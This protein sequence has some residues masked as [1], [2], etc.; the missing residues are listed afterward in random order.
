MTQTSSNALRDEIRK[1]QIENWKGES[2]VPIDSL[3]H[4]LTEPRIREVFIE[5]GLP[6]YS[7][8]EAVKAVLSGGH[9]V[10]GILNEIEHEEL[11]LQVKKDVDPY[12]DKPID[13]GLPYD[14]EQAVKRFLP[15][16][17]TY[18][19]FF[20]TQWRFSAPVFHRNLHY[21]HLHAHTILPFTTNVNLTDQDGATAIVARAELVAC[22]QNI[23]QERAGMVPLILKT[24]SKSDQV[25][26][27]FEHEQH[28]LSL[29]RALQ[30]P[31]IVEFFAAY[32]FSD[33]PTFI[34]AP[35]DCDLNHF[36]R[37][38]QARDFT[39]D[40]IFNGLCGL[41]SALCHLHNYFL[42]DHNLH[43]IGCHYDIHPG[44]ILVKGHT[45]ILS[46]FGL[47]RLKA[48]HQGSKSTFK[49]G[50]MDYYAPECQDWA[51]SFKTGDIGRPSDIWSLGCVMAEILTT[52]VL[53]PERLTQFDEERR[54]EGLTT[55]H[56]RGSENP[57]VTKWIENLSQLSQASVH[58]QYHLG[59]VAKTLKIS[60]ND[61][62]DAWEL[63]GAMSLL[64]H[65]LRH[66]SIM[67]KL[68]ILIPSKPYS[69]EI[70]YERLRIWS[71][72]V[73][74]EEISHNTSRSSWFY[75]IK[76][77]SSLQNSMTLLTEIGTVITAMS[78]TTADDM[79]DAIH[80]TKLRTC[81]DGL[82][83]TQAADTV[84]HMNQKLDNVILG[85]NPECAADITDVAAY[86]R[87]QLLIAVRQAIEAT[88]DYQELDQRLLIDQSNISNS[89]EWEG[90]LMG[91]L[92]T[93]DGLSSYCITEEYQYDDAWIGR[94]TELLNR[95][96][97][98]VSFLHREETVNR[99]PLLRANAFYHQ[100]HR[101]AYGIAFELP[102]PSYV[103]QEG[104][105]P[106]T[107]VQMIERLSRRTER[108]SLDDVYTLAHRIADTVLSFHKASWLHKGISSYKILLFPKDETR[109][110]HS[111][112]SARM[113][114]FHHSR[115]SHDLFTA[116]PRGD[117]KLRE[118]HHP[119]YRRGYIP[120]KE[121]FDYYSVGVVLLEL[122]RWRTLES[123][124][125]K[126]KKT[127]DPTAVTQYLLDTQVPDLKSSM[128]IRYHEAV[129]T[130][131]KTFGVD[132][133]ELE[134]QGAWEL[135]ET[136]VVNALGLG[137][138]IS[139]TLEL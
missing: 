93:A 136:Q 56:K 84:L 95:V 83:Q 17:Q 21:R 26:E 52:V 78:D 38:D 42:R 7:L 49:G 100:P 106:F 27:D 2:F 79:L 87:L 102:T 31:N 71:D 97:S 67:A 64:T 129:E 132:R 116:G 94:S 25:R 89:E 107:L 14:S 20:D 51:R 53:G 126:V 113:L 10:F 80:H 127:M 68:K 131:L 134:G 4:I 88:K 30:H 33:H 130:C 60:Q 69:F 72:H 8:D 117:P 9:R 50:I 13:S 34:F 35:A 22:H 11:I 128:G 70:E 23:T 66:E 32:Y 96:S 44:N 36:L 115:A 57:K 41:S 65:H 48:F 85:Q 59:I 81:I 76:N 19:N 24:L 90:Y 63:L 39:D 108:P 86:P 40:D 6:V 105:K 122:G 114:G 58:R 137:I 15:D 75:K 12:L 5:R 77:Y 16:V 1:L 118:Y 125:R 99:F 104:W 135:F 103:V 139:N 3:R 124:T 73:G 18:R 46:D 82:W 28:V 29:L 92:T 61:R 110:Q 101:Q 43:K 120:F 119:E 121:Q 109:L 98:L 91:R 47:S 138:P 74:L 112:P 54:C 111:L 37:N 123:M 133:N 45:F 55:F 62:P